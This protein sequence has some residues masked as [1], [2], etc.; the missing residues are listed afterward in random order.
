MSQRFRKHTRSGWTRR[1][2]RRL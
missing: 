1:F 2:S